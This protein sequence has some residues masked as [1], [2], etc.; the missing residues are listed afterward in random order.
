MAGDK[1]DKTEAPTQK[2][3]KEARKEGRVVRSEDLVTW[4]LILMSSSVLPGLV[5]RT[6]ALMQRLMRSMVIVAG[7]PDAG[8]LVGGDAAEVSPDAL[9][10][11]NFGEGCPVPPAPCPAGAAFCCR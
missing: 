10:D 4:V 8:L 9:T 2:K 7:N 11:A 3:K 1:H 5:G 6:P